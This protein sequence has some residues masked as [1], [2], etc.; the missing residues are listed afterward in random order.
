[1]QILAKTVLVIIC[2]TCIK[3]AHAMPLLHTK[4]YVNS[5]SVKLGEGQTGGD[6]CDKRNKSED[7][8]TNYFY[9]HFNP[10]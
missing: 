10:V 9:G 7:R 2:N 5:V 8:D 3:S 1:M 6:L 4:F